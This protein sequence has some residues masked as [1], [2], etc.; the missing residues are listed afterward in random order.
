IASSSMLARHVIL[1]VCSVS[2]VRCYNSLPWEHINIAEHQRPCLQHK[3][4][5][6]KKDKPKC[7][8]YEAGCDE[9][10]RYEPRWP[11]DCETHELWR[12]WEQGDFGYVRNRLNELEQLQIC[13]PRKNDVTKSS[14]NCTGRL[15][16]C[17]A[18]DIFLDL[19]HP[20]ST[21]WPR[22]PDDVL[23]A[24]EVGGNCDVDKEALSRQYT[25]GLNGGLRAW[26]S[27]L[28]HFTDVTDPQCDLFIDK[29]VVFM[30]LD[31][32]NNMYHK[33]CGFFNLYISMHVNGS[34]DFN[35]DFM[36]I[37]W[38]WSNVPYNNY[39]EA[40]WSAFSK[41]QVGH[42]RDWF[43]KRV[44][45][46]SAVFSFLP[47]MLLGLFYNAMLGENCSGSG[48]M[49]S[50][51][52]FF[53]HRMNVTQK[54]PIPGKIRVT[55]LQRST[56]PDYL[57]KVY[58]QIVNEKD[59][60]KVLNNIPGF[61]V[62]VVEYHQDTMSFKDQISMSH[63][64]DIMIGM[65]GAGLTHFLFLPPWA[66]AFEL[67]NCQAKCYRDLARLRGVR[68][69]TWSRDDKL[70]T[71]N[72]RE[73]ERDPENRRYW[74]FSFDLE[75]FRRLVLEARDYVLQELGRVHTEL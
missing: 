57:G 31:Q 29:P 17:Q 28:R 41:H 51:S 25:Q 19:R 10:S 11:R 38:D 59:L 45:F 64:S 13:K 5:Q 62:K 47:R 30:K 49:K 36:I 1:I 60:F 3:F 16:F 50:F 46:K 58:R 8:G 67:Y 6:T 70:T 68:H 61:Q 24:D 72:A 40:S 18:R 26:Y 75:E 14:M 52:Q 44:C 27:E 48:M 32:G 2:V 9:L 56:K 4:N 12:F 65:H 34:L 39:F 74:N 35:D 63:N 66:V 7:W 54:G 43:G 55:F 37:N 53:L 20:R 42:I 23:M 73:R 21:K 15:Q 71:H 69:M 33:F 22:H